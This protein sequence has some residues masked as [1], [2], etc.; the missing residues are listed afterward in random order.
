MISAYAIDK[1]VYELLKDTSMRLGSRKIG[2]S[3]QYFNK[4]HSKAVLLLWFLTV[5]CSC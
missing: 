4:D 1:K 3:L 5:T 2:L